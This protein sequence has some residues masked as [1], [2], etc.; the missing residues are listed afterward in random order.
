M[1]SRLDCPT[2]R[3]PPCYHSPVSPPTVGFCEHRIQT[4]KGGILALKPAAAARKS[5]AQ[6]L[7]LFIFS[8]WLPSSHLFYSPWSFSSFHFTNC[9]VHWACGMAPFIRISLSFEA[10]TATPEV[11]NAGDALSIREQTSQQ[12]AKE[13]SRRHQRHISPFLLLFLYLAAPAPP[14]ELN[15]L[16]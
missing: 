10:S 14:R 12:K 9:L 3:I 8:I 15:L 1:P 4:A 13:V 11:K 6:Y 2:P 16:Q 5:C 7:P